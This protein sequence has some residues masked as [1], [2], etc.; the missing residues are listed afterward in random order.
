VQ[1][2]LIL[3]ITLAFRACLLAK[4]VFP[5][6]LGII[7]KT[8]ELSVTFPFHCRFTARPMGARSRKKRKFKQTKVH[9]QKV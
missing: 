8:K 2:E 7:E 6:A 3:K 5:I 9:Y 4:A 1:N